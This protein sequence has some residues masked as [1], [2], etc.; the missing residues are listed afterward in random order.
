MHCP[1]CYVPADP[2]LNVRYAT[3]NGLPSAVNITQD[4]YG[5]RMD[6]FA[7]LEPVGALP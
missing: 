4:N 7:P 6:I 2:T 5:F 3:L 1:V